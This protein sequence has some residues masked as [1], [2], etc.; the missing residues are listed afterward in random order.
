MKPQ[1]KNETFER[2]K[3]IEENLKKIKH[4]IVVFSGKG[5]V[6]K[7]SFAVNLAYSFSKLGY[8]TGIL[9]GDITGPNVPKM[10]GLNHPL[11]VTE[12]KRILPAEING[13]QVVSLATILPPDA[14]VIWRGPLRSVALEQFLG[15]VLWGELDIMVADL[16]PGTGDEILTLIQTM[17]PEIAIIV[18]TPQRV[19]ILDS[20]RAVN[21]AKTMNIKNILIVENM[22]YLVCPHCGKEIDLFGKGTIEIESTRL[23]VEFLGSIPFDPDMRFLSDQGK[24]IVIE[25][26]NAEVTRIYNLMAKRLLK[27]MGEE[28]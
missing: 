7:T 23:G 26:E 17:K 18:S 19:A 13:V 6:G 25:K 20:S 2:K 24:P 27:V 21:M 1:I 5:G 8:K 9:D 15:D 16:P 28:K 12:D 4:K 10:V 3:R 22:S 11:E 14:P